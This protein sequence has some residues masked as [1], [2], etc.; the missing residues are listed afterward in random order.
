M[1]FAHQ[2]LPLPLCLTCADLPSNHPKHMRTVSKRCGKIPT[3]L[4][5]ATKSHCHVAPRSCSSSPA[6]RLSRT[7]CSGAQRVPW[8]RD[9][10][11]HDFCREIMVFLHIFNSIAASPHPKEVTVVARSCF[12]AKT[13]PETLW[14][15]MFSPRV[16]AKITIQRAYLP[17]LKLP[18]NVNFNLEDAYY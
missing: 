7:L 5:S 15:N 6:Q 4:S 11:F 3:I 13:Q 8:R 17:H 16:L 9:G 14:F 2:K 1:A 12:V 18:R 10:V